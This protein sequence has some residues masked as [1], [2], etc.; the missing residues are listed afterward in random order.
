MQ[1]KL[2]QG[3][4][5]FFSLLE[6]AD[7]ASSISVTILEPWKEVQWMEEVRVL[8]ASP[9]LSSVVFL[10]HMPTNP[11]HLSLVKLLTTSISMYI[12]AR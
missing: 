2:A 9:F 10:W 8:K 7:V 11:K 3:Y 12:M 1:K 6:P 5:P 4:V